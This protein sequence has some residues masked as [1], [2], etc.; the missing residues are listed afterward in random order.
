MKA[1]ILSY[2]Y[3]YTY[4]DWWLSS[5]EIQI[6]IDAI[7]FKEQRKIDDEAIRQI[8]KRVANTTNKKGTKYKYKSVSEIANKLRGL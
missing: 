1:W 8:V 7:N 3:D 4:C 5:E 2:D 6:I